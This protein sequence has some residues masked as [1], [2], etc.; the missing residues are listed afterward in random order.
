MSDSPSPPPGFTGQRS[1]VIASA[2]DGAH[3]VTLA[4]Y[5]FDDPGHAPIEVPYVELSESIE[6]LLLDLKHE[7]QPAA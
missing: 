4:V 3:T 5:R 1:H 6:A 2:Q 7:L